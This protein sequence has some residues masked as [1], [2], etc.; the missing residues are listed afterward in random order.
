MTDASIITRIGEITF[1]TQPPR[2]S[3]PFIH[4]SILYY[5]CPSLYARERERHRNR[6]E[7]IDLF[8]T[9]F[10]RVPYSF[11]T[12]FIVPN[13]VLVRFSFF[14]Y[15]FDSCQQLNPSQQTHYQH[16]LRYLAKYAMNCGPHANTVEKT[17]M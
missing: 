6:W 12:F 1:L 7:K 11:S 10:Y 16:L 5:L 8:P 2:F 14:L 17:Y 15:S 4:P 9:G 3:S 13:S